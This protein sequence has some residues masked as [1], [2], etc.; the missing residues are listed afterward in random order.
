MCAETWTS[1]GNTVS[2]TPPRR[3]SWVPTSPSPLRNS[4]TTDSYTLT[5][6]ADDDS[7][8]DLDD[9]EDDEGTQPSSHMLS[10]S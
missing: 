6:S 9:D 8:A 1:P 10:K 5:A 2:T 4:F 3:T 7:E